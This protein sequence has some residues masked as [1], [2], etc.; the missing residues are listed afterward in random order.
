MLLKK[1]KLADLAAL[2]GAISCIRVWKLGNLDAKIMPS[3]TLILRLAEMLNNN[4]GGGVMDFVWGPDIELLETSTE[5]HRFLGQAKYEPVLQAIFMGLGIPLTLYGTGEGGFTN[6]SLSLRTLVERLEYGRDML[7]AF[8]EHEVRLV[9]RGMGFRFPA[10]VVFDRLLSDEASQKQLVLGLWDRNLVSDEYVRDVIGAVPEIEDVRIRREHRRRQ[11]GYLPPKASPFHDANR[12]SSLE[13]IFAQSGAYSPSQFGLELEEKREGEESPTD[14]QAREQKRVEDSQPKGQPGQGRPLNSKDSQ[15]RKQKVVKPR[16]SQTFLRDVNW[17]EQ[18]L[19]RIA[20]LTTEAYLQATGKKSLRELAD[21]E[22]SDLENF[23]LALLCNL[24]FGSEVTQ[25]SIARLMGQP[26]SIPPA[27]SKLIRQALGLY[28]NEQGKQ[29]S[30]E[31][32][33]R[34]SSLACALIL[35]RGDDE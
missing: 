11:K 28:Q 23:K 12:E 10:R 16:A 22:A 14:R 26:L 18:A 7:R 5:V 32:S 20:S 21:Q 6:N 24:P 13:K 19:A 9:Q 31:V 35:G 27:V 8:W 17:A 4:V 30:V 2:D 3:E 34:F 1:L 15:K 33:R 25:Q 29:A